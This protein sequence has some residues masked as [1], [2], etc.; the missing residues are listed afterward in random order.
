V[1][2]GGQWW[3]CGLGVHVFESKV[4][5]GLAWVAVRV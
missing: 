2:V 5:V 4:G 3:Q 1:V